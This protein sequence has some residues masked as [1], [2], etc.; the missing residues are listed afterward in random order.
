MRHSGYPILRIRHRGPPT[1]K[2]MTEEDY[3]VVFRL[4][5]WVKSPE[6]KEAGKKGFRM[7]FT[8]DLLLVSIVAV[9]GLTIGLQ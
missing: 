4:R 8:F 6:A 2:G 3:G 1:P 9:I 5:E 7:R